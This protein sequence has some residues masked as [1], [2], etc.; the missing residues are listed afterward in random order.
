MKVLNTLIE[1]CQREWLSKNS[2]TRALSTE[3][4]GLTLSEH[5]REALKQYIENKEEGKIGK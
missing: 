3:G 1:D 5:V 2:T 4:K